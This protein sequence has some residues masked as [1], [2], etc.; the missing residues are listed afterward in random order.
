MADLGR[1]VKKASA[2]MSRRF[3]RFARRYHLTAVQMSLIDYLCVHKH[4]E[5]YQRDVEH[6]F[7][8]RRSTASVLLKRM[9]KRGLLTRQPS[10]HDARQRQVSLTPQSLQLE[11]TIVQYMRHQQSRLKERFTPAEVHLLVRFLNVLIQ[12][13][14]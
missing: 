6:E 9:A 3:G 12:F 13:N 5:I 4:Q 8:I 10:A 2:Q 11:Q 1:L 7:L 14:Q